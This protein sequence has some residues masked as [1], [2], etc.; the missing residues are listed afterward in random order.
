MQVH[1]IRDRDALSELKETWDKLL[2]GGSQDFPF[3]SWAWYST[4]WKHFGQDGELFVLVAEESHGRVCGI[5]PLYL[6]RTRLRGLPVRELRFLDNSIGPRNAF[7]LHPGQEGIAGLQ[8]MIQC[9]VDHR[10]EWDTATLSN[11]EAESPYLDTLGE[12]VKASGIRT[13]EE[14]G[15]ES[16]V[17]EIGGEFDDYWSTQFRAKQRYNITRRIRM[18]NNSGK[19]ALL[20]Y[21]LPND[22]E[23]ALDLAFQVSR[24]S[25]KGRMG[26]DMSGSA[27]RAAFY[28]DITR[29]LAAE[30]R[31]RIWISLLDGHP[32]ALR[33]Q[34]TSNGTLH[35]LVSDFDEEFR[36]LA[37][38]N[39]LLY[40]VL[41]RVHEQ[42]LQ[43]YEFCGNTYDYERPWATGVKRHVTLQLFNSRTYSK[44]LYATKTRILPVVRTIRAGIASRRQRSQS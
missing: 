25:W 23:R 15:R 22:M 38:G 35:G 18:Q 10:R 37:P 42:G 33:Y 8:A 32:I 27:H 3:Y 44:F 39:V 7:L 26:S 14:S 31:V 5:A 16:P 9:L 2:K 29:S 28:R 30:G 4:W 43:R 21:T 36:D 12:S 24:S 6:R 1:I 20:D 11:I 17:I 40:K 19:H 41:Q 34:L 13:I